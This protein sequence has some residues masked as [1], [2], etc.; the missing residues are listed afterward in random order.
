MIEDRYVGIKSRE[1]YEALRS[2]AVDPECRAIPCPNKTAN[3]P[4]AWPRHAG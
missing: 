4:S 1:V 3:L 2:G